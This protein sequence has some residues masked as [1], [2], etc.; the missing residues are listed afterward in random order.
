MAYSSFNPTNGKQPLCNIYKSPLPPPRLIRQPSADSRLSK[1]VGYNMFE[2]G[3]A[4]SMSNR[5]DLDISNTRS[6][7][8]T[9][10]LCAIKKKKDVWE[11]QATLLGLSNY[12]ALQNHNK[13]LYFI[14]QEFKSVFCFLL[15]AVVLKL[16][17]CI[18]LICFT[19]QICT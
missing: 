5:G 11:A 6:L 13:W 3:V 9:W 19:T 8:Y 12:F 4:F 16:F 10:Q 14:W 15:S 7:T 17:L 1:K 18:R 2:Q